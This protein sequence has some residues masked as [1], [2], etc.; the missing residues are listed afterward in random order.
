ML[1]GV[2]PKAQ[3]TQT[4][5]SGSSNTTTK[6]APTTPAPPP[7]STSTPALPESRSTNAPHSTSPA[8]AAAPSEPASFNDPSALTMGRQREAAIQNVME[9]GYE[10]HE[11]DRAMRAAFYNPDRAVEYLLTVYAPMKLHPIEN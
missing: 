4:D 5:A 10:R 1:T 3:P 7:A 6:T 2:Q 8:V 9:M 11:V